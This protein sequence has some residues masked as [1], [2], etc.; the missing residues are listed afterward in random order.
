[1]SE[2]PAGAKTLAQRISRS[3]DWN[4]LRLKEIF[5]S[6]DCDLVHQTLSANCSVTMF[7]VGEG[8]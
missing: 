1:M 3:E 6:E 5:R 4:P 2:I 8:L 7:D